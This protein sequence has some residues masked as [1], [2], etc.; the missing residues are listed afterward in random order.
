[1]SSRTGS[2]RPKAYSYERVSTGRQ[3]AQGSGLERQSDAAAIWAERNGFDL[4]ATLALSD[5]GSSAFSGQHL[6]SDGALGQFLALATKGQLGPNPVLLVEAID[7]L[8]RLE[9]MDGL[10]QVVFALADAGVAVVTLEDGATYSRD[11]LNNDPSSLIVLVVKTQA[12]HEYSKRLSTRI[13]A[14]WER[15]RAAIKAGVIDRGSHCPH[16]LDFD[17]AT[18]SFAINDHNARSMRRLYE[19]AEQDLGHTLISRRLNEEGLPTARGKRWTAAGVKQCIEDEAPCGVRTLTKYE[20]VVENGKRK[21]K[22]VSTERVEGYFPIL[23]AP[24]RRLAV[25]ARSAGRRTNTGSRGRRGECLWLGQGVTICATCGSI[26]GHARSGGGNRAVSYVRCRA[27][28]N[29]TPC[30]QKY[31]NM[32][33]LA[34]NVLTRLSM[35][36]L[37]LLFPATEN[38]SALVKETTAIQ[39]LTDA[40]AAARAK[41]V[42]FLTRVQEAAMDG[43]ALSLLKTLQDAADLAGDEADSHA[44]ALSAAEGRLALLQQQPSGRVVADELQPLIKELFQDVLHQRDTPEQRWAINQALHRLGLTIHL[45]ANRESCGLQISDGPIQWQPISTLVGHALQEGISGVEIV[46]DE[47]LGTWMEYRLT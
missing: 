16:W 19:L 36:Q 38:T 41:Q 9:P 10:R 33:I 2:P 14:T 1:M 27:R 11:T 8:S 20:P 7:R 37:S 45:D 21:L 25:L 17:P 28:K 13:N 15:T 4:D 44:A 3:A 34:A 43:T 35:E 6:G 24:E 29:A 26:C 23:I 39:A 42:T 18:N 32:R 12:A 5:A 30:G 40:Q 22:P 46:N 47:K 31:A